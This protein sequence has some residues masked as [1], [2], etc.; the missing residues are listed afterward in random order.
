MAYTHTHPGKKRTGNVS[1]RCMQLNLQHSRL[2]TDNFNQFMKEANMGIAFIQ[3]TYI[4]QN[5]VTG[6]SRKYRIF[7]SG[8]RRK[9]AAIVV[10]NKL[11][12]IL[13]IHQLLEE[14]IVGVEI[15]QGNMKFIAAS[16]CL[17]IGNKI[18]EDLSKLENIMWFATGRGLIAAIDNSACSKMW[19]DVLTK[20]G[21]WWKS[22][23]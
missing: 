7:A 1:I 4:Y 5:L 8:H 12:D 3:E 21:D 18:T 16:I 19:H 11:I 9:R 10:T 15:N 14:D 13:V 20:G 23:S 6:I 17:D 2:A 22:L